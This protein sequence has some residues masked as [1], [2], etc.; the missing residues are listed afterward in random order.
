MAHSPRRCPMGSAVPASM[1]WLRAAAAGD[2]A[3]PAAQP[4]PGQDRP[5]RCG[6]AGPPR[7][8]PARRN[9]HEGQPLSR[10]PDCAAQPQICQAVLKG[11]G[12][13]KG[14]GAA[15]EIAGLTQDR[16]VTPCGTGS[17][18][19]VY[20]RRINHRSRRARAARLGREVPDRAGFRVRARYQVDGNA[21]TGVFAGPAAAAATPSASKPAA[22]A[23]SAS[24]AP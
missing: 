4:P 1:R 14:F 5:A 3:S 16:A 19:E 10:T 2:V 13:V 18:S 8:P 15:T 21:S 17:D 7:P 22:S 24:T 12:S 23:R 20:T 9:L 6:R 11:S